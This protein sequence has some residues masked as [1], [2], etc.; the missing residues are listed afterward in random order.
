MRIRI[1]EY[2]A[3]AT[4]FSLNSEE[5]RQARGYGLLFLSSCLL[6]AVKHILKHDEFLLS[7]QSNARYRGEIC[8]MKWIKMQWL[9]EKCTYCSSTRVQL[10]RCCVFQINMSA[11]LII[12][13]FQQTTSTGLH[14]KFCAGVHSP[15]TQLTEST[16]VNC[17]VL[18]VPN[19]FSYL[20]LFFSF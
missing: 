13:Q 12:E 18:F 4:T 8:L 5:Q 2:M 14:V 1:T 11:Y 20:A 9:A 19:I 6:H 3:A 17:D 16:H 7:I 10:G 15:C